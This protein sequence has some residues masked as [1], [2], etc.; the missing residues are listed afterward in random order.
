M[1]KASPGTRRLVGRTPDDIAAAALVLFGVIAAAVTV[2]AI[3]ESYTNL[4]AFAHDHGLHG[5]RAAIAPAAVD[6]FIVMGELLMFAELLKKWDSAVAFT[7]GC[8][9]TVW[10]F[11]LS[12]AG[13]VWHAPSASLTDRLV[14]AIWP[15]TATA[16]LAGGLII[17]RH[18]MAGAPG[19]ATVGSP[20]PD[21]PAGNASPSAPLRREP[22]RAVHEQREARS[23]QGLAAASPREQAVLD[24]AKRE[25]RREAGRKGAAIR[26]ARDK[27]PETVAGVNGNGDG[28]H[29]GG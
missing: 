3:V 7:V 10:G 26:W 15:V 11:G 20:A 2:I 28:S 9:M 14:A 8:G 1:E 5:W 21:S 29:G 13:N 12:V 18:V 22:R 23:G 6:S 4:L 19:R 25:A 27:A 16:G 24:E 17:I